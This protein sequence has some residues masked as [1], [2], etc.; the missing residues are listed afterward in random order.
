MEGNEKKGKK[1]K[2]LSL[3]KRLYLDVS[4]LSLLFFLVFRSNIFFFVMMLCGVTSLAVATSAVC[5]LGVVGNVYS[6]S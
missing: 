2:N 3:W 4:V 1:E 5:W 6:T